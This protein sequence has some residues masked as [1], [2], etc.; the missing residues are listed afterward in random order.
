MK[1]EVITLKKSEMAATGDLRL[2]ND[3]PWIS[4]L[5]MHSVKSSTLR[6]YSI[7]LSGVKTVPGR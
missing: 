6:M 5:G 7:S 2:K 3:I 1:A 4:V